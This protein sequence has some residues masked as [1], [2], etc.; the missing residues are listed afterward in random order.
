VWSRGALTTPDSA[1]VDGRFRGTPE[2]N[3][4]GSD[5]SRAQ[6]FGG[7]REE[8]QGK[9]RGASR[10]LLLHGNGVGRVGVHGRSRFQRRGEGG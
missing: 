6:K 8:L 7:E 3:Q 2:R 1:K 4:G 9:M 5:A 10:G